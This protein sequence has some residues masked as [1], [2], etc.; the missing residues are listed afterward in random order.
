[1]GGRSCGRLAHAARW[2]G[3]VP[4]AHHAVQL[5][6]RPQYPALQRVLSMPLP[7][8]PSMFRSVVPGLA[9]GVSQ[10]DPD[11]L[12][13]VI[14]GLAPGLSGDIGRRIGRDRKSTR[15]N[16]SHVAISYAVFCLKK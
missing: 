7:E 10:S 11:D 14:P 3:A 1:M 12:G 13:S 6:G 15:L 8:E 5:T 16:S 9:P 2:H 4:L